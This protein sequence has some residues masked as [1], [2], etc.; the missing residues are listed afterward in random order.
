MIDF[1][2]MTDDEQTA[3]AA[4]EEWSNSEP[5]VTTQY[6]SKRVSSED[7]DMS[8]R[9]GRSSSGEIRWRN[10]NPIRTSSRLRMSAVV[11]M[12]TSQE[13]TS[14]TATRG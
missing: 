7:C 5:A 10:P 13:R 14:Q 11:S 9:S 6:R 12:S 8:A 2:Q 1:K 4:C 3:M